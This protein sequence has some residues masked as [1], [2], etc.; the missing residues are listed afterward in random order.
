MCGVFFVVVV[1]FVYFCL[2]G[3]LVDWFL[4]TSPGPNV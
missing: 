1:L 3:W 2:F 4:E